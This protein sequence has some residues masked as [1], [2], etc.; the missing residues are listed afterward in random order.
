MKEQTT[1]AAIS[2]RIMTLVAS[3]MELKD[4][5]DAVLGAGMFDKIASD[6]YESLRSK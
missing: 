3:G 6:L 2:L 4:A 5:I 1:N